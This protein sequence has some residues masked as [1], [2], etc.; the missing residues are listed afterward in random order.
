MKL[1][2]DEIIFIR[3]NEVMITKLLNK[4]LEDLKEQV[5]DCSEEKRD[6]IINF[7]KEY[8]LGMQILK[9]LDKPEASNDFSG[10]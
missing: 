8:K 5:L 10:I 6:S 4:R 1:T 3:R 2:K 7:I 9:E